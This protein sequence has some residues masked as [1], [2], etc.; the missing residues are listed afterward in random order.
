MKYL[1]QLTFATILTFTFSAFTLAAPGD[2][3]LDETVEEE[4]TD[5]GADIDELQ[6]R[7]NNRPNGRSNGRRVRDIVEHR[8]QANETL[9]A[10]VLNGV[11]QRINRGIRGITT[12]DELL[13]TWS[14][15]RTSIDFVCADY[16]EKYTL[17]PGG[18]TYSATSQVTFFRQGDGDDSEYLYRSEF[19]LRRCI[20]DTDADNGAGYEWQDEQVAAYDVQHNRL[21]MGLNTTEETGSHTINSIAISPI[22]RLSRTQFIADFTTTSVPIGFITCERFRT[23]VAPQLPSR[24]SADATYDTTLATG[25]I[26][27]T[28]TDVSDVE[29][30]YRVL[31]RLPRAEDNSWRVLVANL[32]ADTTSYDVDVNIGLS[33]TKYLFR[34]QAINENGRVGSNVVKVITPITD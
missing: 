32:P 12:P 16:P 6:N 23:D 2:E 27:L 9:S 14:C 1:T 4:V 21:I 19:D 8:F 20:S 11:F 28:W 3:L 26:A 34:I 22:Q 13:G 24:L 33:K 25:Q 29:T 10:D 30:S 7:R 31:Q 17:D 5:P 15:K 18:L